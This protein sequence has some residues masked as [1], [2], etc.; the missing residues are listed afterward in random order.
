MA[1]PVL[2]VDPGHA[3][4]QALRLRDQRLGGQ[5]EQVHHLGG[6][7]PIRRQVRMPFPLPFAQLPGQECAMV[8]QPGEHMHDARGR[9]QPFAFERAAQRQVHGHQIAHRRSEGGAYLISQN[10]GLAVQ[11]LDDERRNVGGAPHNGDEA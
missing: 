6:R 7:S 11:F 3:R 10:I 9:L 2:P 4:V 8:Q 5:V 1:R